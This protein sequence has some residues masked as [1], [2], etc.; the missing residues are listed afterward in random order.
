MYNYL[1]KGIAAYQIGLGS[2]DRQG[3]QRRFNLTLVGEKDHVVMHRR[4]WRHLTGLRRE[5]ADR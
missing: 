1:L 2:R 4:G 5:S 3:R